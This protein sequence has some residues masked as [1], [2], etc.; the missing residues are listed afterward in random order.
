MKLSSL[1]VVDPLT[2]SSTATASGANNISNPCKCDNPT[3]S[4]NLSLVTE[5]SQSIGQK[6]QTLWSIFS[7]TFLTI[8]LAEMGDKTQLST[9]LIAAESQSPWVVFAGSAIA[10]IATSLVGVLI[11]YWLSQKVSPKTMEKSAGILLIF[12]SV[13][14]LWDVIQMSA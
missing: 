9:L 5:K 1:P 4:D 14:L 3:E 10:L 2:A 7:S 6:Q 13:M 12:I 8:F 11:G